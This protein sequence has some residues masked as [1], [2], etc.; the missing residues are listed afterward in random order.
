M[1]LCWNINVLTNKTLP[2]Y[3]MAK[4]SVYFLWITGPFSLLQ[5]K[6][7]KVALHTLYLCLMCWK[8]LN[9]NFYGISSC[10]QFTTIPKWLRGALDA[11]K[12]SKA[13]SFT[14]WK[15]PC[16]ALDVL[17]DCRQWQHFEYRRS[18]NITLRLCNRNINYYD[19][20]QFR[21]HHCFTC[22]LV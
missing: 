6:C 13:D 18:V 15:V 17:K 1:F 9:A 16:K 19:I 20:F 21:K 7:Q 12:M 5:I 8:L 10:M 22:S 14:S 2:N 11:V 3:K 4:D